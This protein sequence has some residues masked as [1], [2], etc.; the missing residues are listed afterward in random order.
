MS[1]ELR[2]HNR[3]RR[4]P[5][6]STFVQQYWN[7]IISRTKTVDVVPDEA[8]LLDSLRSFKMKITKWIPPVVHVV[9]VKDTYNKE[10]FISKNFC[11]LISV[12]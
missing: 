8:K 11:R 7:F 10:V 9:F 2:N 12:S 3:F 6:Y 1:Y 5:V 4:H